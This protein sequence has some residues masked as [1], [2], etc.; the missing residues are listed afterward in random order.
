MAFQFGTQY[1]RFPTPEPG[2]WDR[3]IQHMKDLGMDFFQ[4]RPQWRSH[5]RIQGRYTWDDLDTLFEL[6]ERHEMSVMFKFMLEAAPEWVYSRYGACRIHPNGQIIHPVSHGAFYVGG[7]LPCFNHPAVIK[8][9][10]AWVTASVNRY[11]KRPSLAYWHAW[12]EPRNRPFGECACPFCN[13][14][15]QIWLK[16]RFG[17]I[18]NYNQTLGLAEPD[19]ASLKPQVDSQNYTT[20]ALWKEWGR[21]QVVERVERVVKAIRSKDNTRKVM[22]HV[23]MCSLIQDILNDG[24]DD[25]SNAKVPDIYGCSLPAFVGEF[26]SF[27]KISRIAQ[28]YRSDWRRNQF[29]FSMMTDW[30]RAMGKPFWVNELYSNGWSMEDPDLTAEDMRFRIYESVGNGAK[31]INLWQFR[32]ER[33]SCESGSAGLIGPDGSDTPRSREVKAFN[34][35]KVENAKILDTYKKDIGDVAIVY[36]VESDLVSRLEQAISSN[37]NNSVIYRYKNSIK[38]YY[39]MLWAS[40]LNVDFVPSQQFQKIAKY[41]GVIL[42]YFTRLDKK[43]A[44]TL[45]RYVKNGGVV[46]AD[47]GLG[48]RDDRNWVREV[49]PPFGLEEVFGVRHG[50]LEGGKLKRQIVTNAYGK[51]KTI[52]F[53]YFPGES[54]FLEAEFG[55]DKIVQLIKRTVGCKPFFKAKGLVVVKHGRSSTKRVALILNYEKREQTVTLLTWNKSV[56]VAPREVKLIVL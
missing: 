28:F 12:N 42:P 49:M 41:P 48:L 25:F 56:K 30:I 29:V 16:N 33:F 2:Q 54:H 4:V 20:L 55:E 51:G 7:W 14:K 10:R 27:A 5:E 8:A 6:A 35:F 3:D 36:D 13:K 40:G 52:Y 44:Y 50:F 46:I 1:Y 15:Y 37:E 18:E 39:A 47:P 53:G 19:F 11:K 22:T 23:G 24:S 45:R 9:T 17:T 38:G 31:G 21:Q 43:K 34:R 26:E 32:P